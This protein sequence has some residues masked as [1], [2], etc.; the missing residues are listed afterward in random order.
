MNL[1]AEITPCGCSDGQRGGLLKLAEWVRSNRHEL[2]ALLLLGENAAFRQPVG[3]SNPSFLFM[4]EKAVC[5]AEALSSVRGTSGAWSANEKHWL[6]AAQTEPPSIQPQ[7][8]IRTRS[9]RAVE[10]SVP[11]IAPTAAF[12][13][14]P[15]GSSDSSASN[16]WRIL[17]V[18]EHDTHPTEGIDRYHAIFEV[19]SALALLTRGG[20]TG[21]PRAVALEFPEYGGRAVLV[22][23]IYLPAQEKATTQLQL[24]AVDASEVMASMNMIKRLPDERSKLIARLESGALKVLD[25][26]AALLYTARTVTIS[27]NLPDEDALRGRYVEFLNSFAVQTHASPKDGREHVVSCQACHRT[28]CDEFVARDPHSHAYDT[29]VKLQDG[30]HKNPD[31]LRCHT[32][33]IEQTGPKGTALVVYQGVQCESCHQNASLHAKRPNLISA[34]KATPATCIAC[35]TQAQDPKFNYRKCVVHLGCSCARR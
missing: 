18:S 4:S 9:R 30:S 1:H 20:R 17:I 15:P 6:Q 5:V 31:C 7:I 13:I 32:T 11:S 28:H 8:V 19:S 25:N 3:G 2:D 35:H 33:T 10:L 22:L 16:S 34:M 26:P 29:L 12:E 21:T 24:K 23:T 27:N 14:A